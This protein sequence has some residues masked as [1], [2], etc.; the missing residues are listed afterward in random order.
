MV[1]ALIYIDRLIASHQNFSLH[2]LNFHR[3]FL[4]R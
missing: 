3:L 4:T 2:S 1:V